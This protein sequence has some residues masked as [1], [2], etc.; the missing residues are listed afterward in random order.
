MTPD[1]HK[2]YRNT[3]SIF[4]YSVAADHD[5][6]C[7]KNYGLFSRLA[8]GVEFDDHF[9][10]F[11]TPVSDRQT[12]LQYQYRVLHS[13]AMLTLDKNVITHSIKTHTC[14][15]FK[16]TMHPNHYL[17]LSYLKPYSSLSMSTSC[18]FLGLSRIKIIFQEFSRPGNL[19]KEIPGVKHFPG[20][21]VTLASQLHIQL[22]TLLQFSRTRITDVR[23]YF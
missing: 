23:P 15:C 13:C 16:C 14:M 12:E 9:S 22:E 18:N 2:Q 19:T 8:C 11:N 3:Y 4:K 21:V 10:H 6:Q 7:W 17:T 1:W 20:G 5:F